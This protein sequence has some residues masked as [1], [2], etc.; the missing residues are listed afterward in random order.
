MM[1]DLKDSPVAKAVVE[2][3]K[4]VLSVDPESM[5]LSTDKK[6]TVIIWRGGQGIKEITDISFKTSPRG[7]IT[8]PSGAGKVW[9]CVD[10]CTRSGEWAYSI[11]ATCDDGYEIVLD[12]MIRNT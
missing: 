5:E 7:Q 9:V 1:T 3:K 6:A 2:C 11:S 8:R 12:P 10:R 4:G